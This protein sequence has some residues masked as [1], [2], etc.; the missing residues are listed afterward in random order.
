MLEPR[1]NF[2]KNDRENSSN[3]YHASYQHLLITCV[4]Y[5]AVAERCRCSSGGQYGRGRASSPIGRQGKAINSMVKISVSLV[6]SLKI[7]AKFKQTLS[8]SFLNNGLHLFL[9]VQAAVS[10]SCRR[11]QVQHCRIGRRQT[12]KIKLPSEVTT[13]RQEA[14]DNGMTVPIIHPP[15]DRGMIALTIRPL[16]DRGMTIL[17]HHQENRGMTALTTHPPEGRGM[18]ALMIRPLGDR[19]KR[20]PMS[21]PPGE[22]QLH[23]QICRP[24]E[25]VTQQQMSHLQG[26]PDLMTQHRYQAELA[27]VC[28]LVR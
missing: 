2:P 24:P 23:S 9:F 4:C 22:N 20:A 8:L 6:C 11:S 7:S 27:R 15:E 25:D 12:C 19:D 26:G 13:R 5:E 10:P 28:L 18:T 21:H 3:A 1:A 16:G 14:G 17:S